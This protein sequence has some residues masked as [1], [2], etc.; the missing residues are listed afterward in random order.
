MQRLVTVLQHNL[1]WLK[2][3]RARPALHMADTGQFGRHALVRALPWVAFTLLTLAFVLHTAWTNDDSFI[4]ARVVDNLLSSRGLRWNPAERVQA[5]THPLW[6]FAM[7]GARCLVRDAYWS[8][9]ALCVSCS[10]CAVGV[11]AWCQPRREPFIAFLACSLALSKCFVDYATSGLENSLSYL[12]IVLLWRELNWQR[13]PSP[14]KASLL[15]ALASL[16]RLDLALLFGPPWLGLVLR[17][18]VRPSERIRP[19]LVAGLPLLI[20]ELFSL[21]YFGFLVP[22]TAIAKLTSG[23]PRLTLIE[24]GFD[25]L[26]QASFNDPLSLLVLFVGLPWGLLRGRRAT[27]HFCG[28]AAL[29]VSYVIWIGGDFMGGRFLAAPVLVAVLALLEL[30]PVPGRFVQVALLVLALGLAAVPISPNWRAAGPSI[31]TW[32]VFLDTC[33][34]GVCDQ[35]VLYGPAS[36]WRRSARDGVRPPDANA[37]RGKRFSLSPE[38]TRVIG[39]IGY[40]GFFAG[41]E[42]FIVDHYG[43]SDA[44]LARLPNQSSLR[45][46]T[47]GHLR[48]CV[49]LGYPEATRL[50][51]SALVDPGLRDYYAKIWLVTRGPLWTRERF[52]AIWQLNT[53]A[54]FFDGRY[55][56]RRPSP[57]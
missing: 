25:Y 40:A 33:Q 6:L 49:P 24:H 36:N 27:R 38:R 18:G 47:A 45:A 21:V 39:A 1:G 17:F 37:L 35:R 29:Y 14:F 32:E 34:A 48:R 30:A 31:D 53:S 3:I 16:N 55:T 50:G 7:A 57:D 5:F 51:P 8:L 44:L 41:P 9:L 43:L 42:V 12:L 11:I 54:R 28:G 15:L 56:C 23:L 20:W 4:S 52:R 26:L 10:A 46:W 22:N 19:W 2:A 13:R